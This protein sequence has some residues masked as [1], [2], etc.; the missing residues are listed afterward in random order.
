G[1]FLDSPADHAGIRAGDIK[2]AIN[3]DPVD[4]IR[5]LLEII[6]LHRPGEL[7]EV[8]VYRGS[9]KMSFS[10]RATERPAL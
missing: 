9:E 1:V 10:M 5:D 2:V 6:T 8:T 4:S 7:I 3:R